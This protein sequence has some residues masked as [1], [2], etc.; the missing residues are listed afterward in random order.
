MLPD[1]SEAL[2]PFLATLAVIGIIYGALCAWVQSDVKK[3]VA[4]SSVS[5]L[6]F[7]MLGM[8]SPKMAGGTGSV[9]T[10]R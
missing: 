7:C 10:K 8:L 2:A 5:H 3:L 1:A 4:S 9:G 6:G